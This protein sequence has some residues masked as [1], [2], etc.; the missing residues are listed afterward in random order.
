M[1]SIIEATVAALAYFFHGAPFL[2]IKDLFCS[3]IKMPPL[4]LVLTHITPK[5]QL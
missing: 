3:V 4:F 2:L 1:D 5:T